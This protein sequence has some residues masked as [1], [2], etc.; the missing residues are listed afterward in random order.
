MDSFE[1]LVGLFSVVAA[2]GLARALSGTAK[3]V[4]LRFEVTVSWIH[5]L[6]A[7]N[8][9]VWLVM[10]WWFSFPLSEVKLWNAPLLF[11][12]TDV[13]GAYLFSSRPSVSGSNS[14]GNGFI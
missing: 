10:F 3:L 5:L 4:Y 2:L 6:W 14:A 1:Y 12:C 11:F 9:I 13:R 8:V 7:A